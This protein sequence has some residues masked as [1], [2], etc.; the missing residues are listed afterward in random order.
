MHQHNMWEFLLF[1]REYL[2]RKDT[3]Q[4][5]DALRANAYATSVRAQAHGSTLQ[6]VIEQNVALHKDV[7]RLTL[8]VGVLAEALAEKGLIDMEW[9]GPRLRQALEKLEAP[10][11]PPAPPKHVA[12][13][14]PVEPPPP[15]APAW[16]LRCDG[17]HREVDARV[18]NVTEDGTLCDDCYKK[19]QVSAL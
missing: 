3:E 4:D 17:C 1:D 18:T 2:F 14:H 8:M 12:A 16:R 5:L 15:A 7:A 6:R 19:R 13:P 9:A 11:P 10:P